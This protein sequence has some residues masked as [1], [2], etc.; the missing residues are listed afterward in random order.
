MRERAEILGGRL[1]IDSSPHAGT[2][3]RVELP[4]RAEK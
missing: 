4:L 2:R 3:I 1:E